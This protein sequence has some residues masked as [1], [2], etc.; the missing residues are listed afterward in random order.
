MALASFH[1]TIRSWFETHLGPP[2]TA[3][4]QGWSSIRDGH[5]TLIAAPTGSGKTLAAFLTAIDGLLRQGDELADQ[6]QVL[7]ISPL[8]ALGNDIAKNLE[9]PL[10][11]MREIDATL[12]EIRVVVRSGD[13]PAKDRTAMMR[14]QPHILVTTPDSSSLLGSGSACRSTCTEPSTGRWSRGNFNDPAKLII[15]IKRILK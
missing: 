3:Q 6:T 12:P 5:H 1:P 15:N 14:K 9:L 2:T 13:T 7:Y 4:E 10:R 8:K 11:Q